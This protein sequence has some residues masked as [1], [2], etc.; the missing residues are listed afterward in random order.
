M[1]LSNTA[2]TIMVFCLVAT[3]SEATPY[4]IFRNALNKIKN[5]INEV[6][7]DKSAPADGKPWFCHELDCP[8]FKTVRKIVVKKGD[9]EEDVTIEERCYPQTTWVKTALDGDKDDISKLFSCFFMA[10]NFL[11]ISY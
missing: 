11:Y 4:N 1:K 8:E 6:V 9:D 7:G 3:M 5:S 2:R 10:L